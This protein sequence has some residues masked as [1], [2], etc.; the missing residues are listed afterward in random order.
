MNSI[1]LAERIATV[2]SEPIVD[3]DE[4]GSGFKL[5]IDGAE[6]EGAAGESFATFDPAT[7]RP[8][9][10][11]AKATPADVDVAVAAAR[12]AFE[13]TW[14]RTSATERGRLLQAASRRI[15][16][17]IEPLAVI[18]TMDSGKP[19]SQCRYD[20][21]IAARYLELFGNAAAGLNGDHI[22]VGPNLIDFTVRQP[23]GVSAQIN[24]WNFPINMAARSIGAALAAGNTVVVKTPELAPV[25]TAILGRI[26]TEV[27]VPAGVVNIIHGSGSVIGDALSKHPDVDL[28]TFTGSMATGSKV[29]ANAASMLTPAV[30]ELGG[31]SP[32]LVFADADLPKAARQLA[33]GFVEANGQSCDL[34]SLALVHE[35]AHDE[36]VRL[37]VENVRQFTVTP[38]VE[39]GTVSAVISERQL[40]IVSDFVTGAVA[41]G[42]TVAIG[43]SRASGDGL[44]DGWFFEPTI[45]TGVTPQMRVAREEIF[46]PVLS[47]LT[48]RDEEEAVRIANG[49][50]YGLAAFVWTRDLARGMRLTKRIDAGQV[51]V[52]CFSSGDS[53]MLPFGGFKSSGYGREKGVEALRTYTQVKNV[54]ISTE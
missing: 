53:P 14:S 11:L 8:I 27:G 45:L 18:E 12:R 16:E 4:F 37:L 20:V 49:T 9:Y 54:C 6:V 36:F 7:G 40:G 28:I 29:A 22:P 31:K 19:L 5:I 3:A 30:M 17:L 33:L 2:A 51:Y 34:P 10:T 47:V 39:D 15:L 50:E 24:A 52:N 26:F 35:D 44:D 42:A 41:E 23:F 46:G 25:T 32:V 43:G 1:N 38:G 21:K 13:E 48:F